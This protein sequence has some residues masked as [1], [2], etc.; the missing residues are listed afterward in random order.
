MIQV[1][2][3]ESEKKSEDL[4]ARVGVQGAWSRLGDT[5][6][7]TAPKIL[8]IWKKNRRER[9]TILYRPM[10]VMTCLSVTQLSW[11]L[12]A[13]HHFRTGGN[14]FASVR[15]SWNYYSRMQTSRCCDLSSIHAI[16]VYSKAIRVIRYCLLLP[17]RCSHITTSWLLYLE[18]Y[19]LN[20][21]AS[22]LWKKRQKL[23][24]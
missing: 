2:A 17:S 15:L 16:Q 18:V 3:P 21:S 20:H 8:D 4:N 7:I 11:Q 19:S 9:A 6:P 10:I 12:T 22:A 13:I 23:A 1:I 24:C 5:L 14:R